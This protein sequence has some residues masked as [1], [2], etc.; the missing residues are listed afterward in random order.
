GAFARFAAAFSDS[1]EFLNALCSDANDQAV[2]LRE[3]LVAAGASAAISQ[4]EGES[5]AAS[6]V[7]PTAAMSGLRA[8]DEKYPGI[9]AA[10]KAKID[11]LLSNPPEL[12]N[13]KAHLT[14][15]HWR[16]KTRQYLDQ[17]MN[18]E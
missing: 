8:A 7:D 10:M 2:A 1:G 15:Q 5:V 3:A 6:P 16:T 13:L 14:L 11:E 18:A 4:A 9:A 17:L 12:T